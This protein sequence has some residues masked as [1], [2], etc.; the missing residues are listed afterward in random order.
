MGPCETLDAGP[1]AAAPTPSDTPAP[2]SDTGPA[3]CTVDFD[4]IL[5]VF[6]AYRERQLVQSPES[7]CEA[8]VATSNCATGAWARYI[9]RSINVTSLRAPPE[10]STSIF[11]AALW[12]Q[13]AVPLI[14]DSHEKCVMSRPLVANRP[15]G[16]NKTLRQKAK[17]AK[18]AVSSLV[19]QSRESR[20]EVPTSPHSTRRSLRR[21]QYKASVFRTPLSALR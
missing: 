14:P 1:V 10:G 7:G 4:D 9:Q 18:L 11:R 17:W 21:N 19:H 6:A 2:A 12:V 20:R 13:P 3:T 15:R 5:K 16:A 8:S